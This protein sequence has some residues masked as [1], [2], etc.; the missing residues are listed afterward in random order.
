MKKKSKQRNKFIS[1][2]TQ[3]RILVHGV[4]NSVLFLRRKIK[5]WFKFLDFSLLLFTK[6][7]VCIPRKHQ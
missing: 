6:K 5:D 2:D 1:L 7:I 3:N 4:E